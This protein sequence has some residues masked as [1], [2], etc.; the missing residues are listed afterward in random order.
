[1]YNFYT[2]GNIKYWPG[3]GGGP[4]QIGTNFTTIEIK[5]RPPP[6]SGQAGQAGG[7]YDSYERFN[8]S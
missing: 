4:D 3:R 8:S 2:T 7:Q 6:S 1:L 5:G